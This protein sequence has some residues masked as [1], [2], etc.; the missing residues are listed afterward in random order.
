MDFPIPGSPPSS[1]T[2][3][4]TSPP[5]STRSSSPIRTDRRVSPPGDASDSA[6]GTAEAPVDAGIRRGSSRTTVST[7]VFHSPQVRHWPSQR[8]TAVPHDWQT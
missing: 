3:P 4:A 7:R 1:T 5:P 6:T 2:E 8:S